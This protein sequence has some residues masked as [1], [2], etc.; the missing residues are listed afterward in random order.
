M[1]QRKI[2]IFLVWGETTDLLYEP[3]MVDDDECGAVGGMIGRGNRIT[4]RKPAPLSLC[5]PQIPHDL[6]RT[7]TLAA[8]VGSRGLTA[9]AKARPL[10]TN[11]N[12]M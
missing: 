12:L 9:W 8:K 3:R 6:T 7:G 5:P 10:W 4:R 1:D 11:V 2:L